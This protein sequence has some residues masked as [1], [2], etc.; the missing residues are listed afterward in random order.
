MLIPDRKK[1]T[2]VVDMLMD[3]RKDLG[4]L[5]ETEIEER[6]II[7]ELIVRRVLLGLDTT[8][9]E[10]TIPK[11]CVEEFEISKDATADLKLMHLYAEAVGLKLNISLELK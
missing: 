6:K 1:Y 4:V 11:I 10:P 7:T 2:S 3:I 5:V 8:F 9:L